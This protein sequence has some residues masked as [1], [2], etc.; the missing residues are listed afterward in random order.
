MSLETELLP[1]P[2]CGGIQTDIRRETYWTGMRS[3]LLSVTVM[4]WCVR[5]SGDLQSTIQI[6][7]KTEE[8]AIDA[9]NSR[10]SSLPM[11]PRT[12][13]ADGDRLALSEGAAKG[14]MSDD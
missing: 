1:C 2:F 14:G 7:R 12:R 4:H 5:P 3:Q 9:W 8:G 10:A 6:K 11:T 13:T